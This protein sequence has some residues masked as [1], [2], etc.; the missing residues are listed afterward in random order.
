MATPFAKGS[1]AGGGD[2]TPKQVAQIDTTGL[3]GNVPS[4]PKDDRQQLKNA[5]PQIAS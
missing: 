3:L 5:Y 1:V 4:D 2:K